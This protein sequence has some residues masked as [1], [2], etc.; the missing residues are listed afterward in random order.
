LAVVIG[1]MLTPATSNG[2]EGAAEVPPLSPVVEQA[3]NANAAAAE[4]ASVASDLIFMD[5]LLL[6]PEWLSG[7]L[8][9][10]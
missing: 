8:K 7:K 10:G 9:G 4:T 6:C 3:A 1:L 5:S 2:W